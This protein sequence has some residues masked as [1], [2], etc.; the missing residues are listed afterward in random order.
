MY[1]KPYTKKIND[2]RMS[3]RYQSP[4]FQQFDGK[5]NPNQQIAHFVETCENAGSRG[6]QLVRSETKIERKHDGDEK[7]HPT[8]IERQKKVYPFLDFDAADM[9]EQLLENQLIQLPKRKRLEQARKADD[10]NYCKSIIGLLV[11]LWKSV[12]C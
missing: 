7:R 4:K 10:P 2:L 9:L 6:E 12:S 8:L 11:T 1:S 3:V 5:G